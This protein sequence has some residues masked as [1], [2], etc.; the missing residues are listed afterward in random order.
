MSAP[1]MS[2]AY[3]CG[4][5]GCGKPASTRPSPVYPGYLQA[6]CECGWASASFKPPTA[7]ERARRARQLRP[8]RRG[9]RP[10]PRAALHYLDPDE[11]GA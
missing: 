1:A 5:S 7:R 10:V 4:A 3:V 6:V 2:T 8:R 9:P 11:R